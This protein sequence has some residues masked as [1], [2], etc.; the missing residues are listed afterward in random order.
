KGRRLMAL[1]WPLL[2]SS[3]DG[4]YDLAAEAIATSVR[5]ALNAG[6]IEEAQHFL[7]QGDV[8]ASRRSLPRLKGVIAGWRMVTAVA[9]QNVEA[10]DAARSVLDAMRTNRADGVDECGHYLAEAIAFAEAS[11]A[12]WRNAPRPALEL[13]LGEAE[14]A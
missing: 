2:S 5:L 10:I 7:E 8:I 4:W 9:S 11:H 13:M 12:L 6:D 3:F 1:G 14:R